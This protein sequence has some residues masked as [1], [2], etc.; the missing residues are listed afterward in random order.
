MIWRDLEDQVRGCGQFGWHLRDLGTIHQGEVSRKKEG[1]WL[2]IAFGG[3]MVHQLTKNQMREGQSCHASRVLQWAGATP[4]GV[5]VALVGVS[6]LVIN[7]HS[8][9]LQPGPYFPLCVS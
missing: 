1:S 4:W 5:N 6:V 3:T 2:E 9:L 8:L 7:L